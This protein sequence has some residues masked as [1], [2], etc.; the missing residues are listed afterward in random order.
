MQ[1]QFN[2]L[3]FNPNIWGLIEVFLFSSTSANNMLKIRSRQCFHNVS[4]PDFA[5]HVNVPFFSSGFACAWRRHAA[6]RSRFGG[7]VSAEKDALD[8]IGDFLFCVICSY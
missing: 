3:V 2:M 4:F 1:P 7:E 8:S 5:A 6:T